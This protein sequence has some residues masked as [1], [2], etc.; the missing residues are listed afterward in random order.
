MQVKLTKMQ[1]GEITHKLR[2][3][4]DEEDMQESYEISSEEAERLHSLFYS[5]PAGFVDVPDEWADML[6]SEL[7]NCIDIADANIDAG[8]NDWR[9]YKRQIRSAIKAI[10]S[11]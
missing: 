9:N 10:E 7:E 11:A 8:D 6:V 3:I 5:S 4:A 1:I 2:I